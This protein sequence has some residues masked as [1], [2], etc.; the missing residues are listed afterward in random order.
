MS[1]DEFREETRAW[2]EENCPTSMRTPMPQDEY[3]GGGRRMQYKNPDTKIWM[4]RMAEKGFTVPIW[5]REYGGAGLNSNEARVLR[6]EMS[7]IHAR[8]PLVGM[9]LSMIGP[10]LLEY[11]NE[12]QKAEHLPKIARGEIWW[13]Q[14]YSEPNS[15]SDLASLQTKAIVDGDDYI[16]NGQKIWTSGADNADWIFC[17]VRTDFEAPKHNGITF[18][19]FDMTSPGV[20]V[21]PIKLIS[22]LSPFCE[23]FFNDVRVPRKNVVSNVNEGWTVAKRLL[24][25]ERTMIG[26]GG[27]GGPRTQSLAEIA[28]KYIGK[29]DGK[30]SDR[31]LREEITQHSMDDRAFGLTVQRNQEESQSTKAPSFVSSMFKMYGTE[32]NKTR[33][34]LM[35]KSMGSQM[36]GWEGEGFGSS[37]LTQ[38]RAWLRTKA[39]SI[40]GGTTEVQLNIIAKRVLGLPD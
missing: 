30:L 35:L 26:G 37:E 24:Q 20:S 11:G 21:K 18:I 14:G 32:Q 5:P 31:N 23:T 9:G 36:L 4:D 3:P 13:C 40:E 6:E 28:D 19:L 16:I 27:G 34:E 29:Q 7:R 12:E 15:G 2:L 17:L 39:N 38:T 1:L 25:Y 22:G 8:T 33:Y 10:A